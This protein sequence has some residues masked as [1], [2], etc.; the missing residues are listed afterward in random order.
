MRVNYITLAERAIAARRYRME[1]PG[2]YIGDYVVSNFPVKADIHVMSK[3]YIKDE[4]L[5]D[6]YLTRARTL[7]F[8]FDLCDPHFTDY[9]K[10][11]ISMAISVTVPTKRMAELVKENT[12]VDAVV[13]SDPYEFPESSIKDISDKKVM[14]FGHPTNL[15][16]LDVDYPVE[17]V[18]MPGVELK[19]NYTFTEWSME[20][21]QK[22]FDRNNVVII[23]SKNDFKSPNR[24]VE[25]IRQGLSV[26]ATND[27]GLDITVNQDM[28]L[29]NVKQT[30]PELQKYV[31][32]NFNISV[33][34]EKW[35]QLFE[36]VLSSTSDAV[37]GF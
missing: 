28:N 14:W 16:F 4:L 30:T 25:A 12:G 19:K 35:K 5:L 22:A 15:K 31:R 34:G 13:I 6:T 23:P 37:V 8:I 9:V 32:D 2:K 36:K 33:I 7:D 21:M 11:M 26:V 1:L 29:D 18:T 20:N 3:P 27:Y 17:V 24:A 10:E